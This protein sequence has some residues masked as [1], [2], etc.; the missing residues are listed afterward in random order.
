M[1]YSGNYIGD[2][3]GDTFDM[4]EGIENA[5]KGHIAYDTIEKGENEKQASVLVNEKIEIENR[6]QDMLDENIK[7]NALMITN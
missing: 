7:Q 1:R 3:E 5:T 2:K 6:E 4:K